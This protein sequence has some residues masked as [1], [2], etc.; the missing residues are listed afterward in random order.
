MILTLRGAL[1]IG[2]AILVIVLIL[3]TF[4]GNLD[5]GG[6]TELIFPSAEG[7]KALIY[8]F[9]F[10]GSGYTISQTLYQSH[11]QYYQEYS[12][13]IPNIST[14]V[15]YYQFI[16]EM[17]QTNDAITGIVG[18]LQRAAAEAG[19]NADQTLEFAMRFVQSIPYDI[20]KADQ[21]TALAQDSDSPPRLDLLPRH[22]YVT[23]YDNRGICS[24]KTVLA[25]AIAAEMGYGTAI[26]SFAGESTGTGVGHVGL[27]IKCPPTYS[28]YNSG[29][30]YIETT[31]PLRVG[32]TDIVLTPDLQASSA[33][34]TG[35]PA[36]GTLSLDFARAEVLKLED[37]ATYH[38]IIELFRLEE[39][40]QTLAVLVERQKT[41][42]ERQLSRLNQLNSSLIAMGDQNIAFSVEDYDLVFEEYSREVE[43]FNQLI[44]NHN[45]NVEEY[46]R[47]VQTLN[48]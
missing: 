30:C 47:A 40:I 22:P 4:F 1:M 46:N 48:D 42:I 12:E 13:R 34:G 10:L 17:H 18:S 14:P 26:F 16:K 43:S 31:A 7:P 38:G 45:R 21:V 44:E 27:G 41:E 11:Y 15:D 33:F 6:Q 24:D 20:T 9:N 3:M 36:A 2:L 19:F 8:H 32:M 5:N 28:V 29:Y 35:D 23:L 39:R 25:A 37:G